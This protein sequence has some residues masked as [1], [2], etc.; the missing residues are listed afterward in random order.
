MPIHDF[1]MSTAQ[2]IVDKSRNVDR[3]AMEYGDPTEDSPSARP[4]I[5]ASIGLSPVSNKELSYKV[6]ASHLHDTK[7]VQFPLNRARTTRRGNI[8]DR[9]DRIDDRIETTRSLRRPE[10]QRSPSLGPEPLNEKR[11][12][13]LRARCRRANSKARQRIRVQYCNSNSCH[14]RMPDRKSVV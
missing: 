5:N 9:I 14:L 4:L 7:S 6:V 12:N 11:L 8:D 10:C 3:P 13:Q 1:A 2:Q